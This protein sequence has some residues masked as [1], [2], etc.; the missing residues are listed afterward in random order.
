MLA[1][2]ANLLEMVIAQH[3]TMLFSKKL[4]NKKM[5]T[6]RLTNALYYTSIPVL[7]NDIDNALASIANE[8]YYNVIYSLH[9]DVQC[10]PMSDLLNYKSIVLLQSKI[11]KF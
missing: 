4:N 7:L 1:V 6:P 11:L 8:L 3:V 9:R 5:L 10:G 2:D